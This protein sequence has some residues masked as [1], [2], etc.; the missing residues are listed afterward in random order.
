MSLLNVII[1]RDLTGGETMR[2]RKIRSKQGSQMR[3]Q[4]QS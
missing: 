1:D 3:E 4:G 2:L